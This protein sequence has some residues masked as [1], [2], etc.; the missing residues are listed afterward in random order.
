MTYNE[1]K[2]LYESIIKD[3]AKIVKSKINEYY[4]EY[5]EE[6]QVFLKAIDKYKSKVLKILKR[7]SELKI[8][9]FN[10]N[11]P[12][13]TLRLMF[14]DYVIRYEFKDSIDE[15]INQAKSDFAVMI[16][17]DSD[18]EFKDFDDD[19]SEFILEFPTAASVYENGDKNGH[20]IDDE[21][22][23]NWENKITSSL[24]TVN[25]CYHGAFGFVVVF[26]LDE[27]LNT[28][29]SDLNNLQKIGELFEKKNH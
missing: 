25:C 29:M 1:K 5:N 8:S 11:E 19:Y 13:P 26:N 3:V 28:I 27:D 15:F 6:E 17:A 7:I 20:P 2:F 9:F 10:N 22:L 23:E 21:I 18:E 14:D 12:F 4:D 24:E 16:Y